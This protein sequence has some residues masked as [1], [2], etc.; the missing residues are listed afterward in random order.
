[1]FK[2]AVIGTVA[3]FVASTPV[4]QEMVNSIRAANAL[5]NPVEVKDNIFANYSME[6]FKSLLGTVVGAESELPQVQ[7]L[8]APASFDSRT[9]WPGCV[10]AIRD[11]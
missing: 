7:A 10:H 8:D 6:Q 4:S 9:Q 5:W 3:T 2:L 11:Q 1:M